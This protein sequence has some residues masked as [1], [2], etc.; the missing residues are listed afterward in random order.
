MRKEELK[1]VKK[2]KKEALKQRF[3]SARQVSINSFVTTI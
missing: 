3:I 2:L 1:F